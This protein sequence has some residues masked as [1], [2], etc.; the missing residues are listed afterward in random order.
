MALSSLP[1]VLKRPCA[2]A[3]CCSATGGG[4]KKLTQTRRDFGTVKKKNPTE[5]IQRCCGHRLVVFWVWAASQLGLCSV[6]PY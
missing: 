4:A 6:L 3:Q 5:H 1:T 2:R